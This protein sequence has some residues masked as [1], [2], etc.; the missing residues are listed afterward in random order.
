MGVFSILG[1]ML[2]GYGYAA[3]S[4]DLLISG[5]GTMVSGTSFGVKTMQELTPGICLNANVGTEEQLTDERDDKKYWVAKLAD[6]NCWMAQNL[7]YDDPESTQVSALS[8]WVNTTNFR[9]F[10]DPGDYYL[11]NPSSWTAYPN[12]GTG[13]EPYVDDNLTT[14]GDAHYH[15]G[16]Y[17]SWQSATNGSGSSTAT[18]GIAADSICPAGWQLPIGGIDDTN[19]NKP[20][21]SYAKLME[22]YGVR[23]SDLSAK[24]RDKPAYVIPGGYLLSR[25][26]RLAGSVGRY[27]TANAQSASYAYHF[28]ISKGDALAASNMTTARSAGCSLRCLVLAE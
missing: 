10:Y 11:V 15:V 20:N 5:I 12:N 14:S 16:N 13:F 3:V 25:N 18:G 23:L 21:G 1:I 4:T 2:C 27:W 19:K 17:Y 28:A 7:D 22:S 8:A 6:G 26:L 24:L 9:A